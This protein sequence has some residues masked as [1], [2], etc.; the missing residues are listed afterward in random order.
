M[1]RKAQLPGHAGGSL[2]PHSSEDRARGFPRGGRRRWGN[3]DLAF[4]VSRPY[5]AGHTVLTQ[6][7]EGTRQRCFLPT[8]GFPRGHKD[9]LCIPRSHH[10]GCRVLCIRVSV[11]GNPWRPVQQA[12]FCFQL[13]GASPSG[14]LEVR[15]D[16]G[17]PWGIRF[18]SR[19]RIPAPQE[20]HLG[21]PPDLKGRLGCGR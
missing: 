17:W 15:G 12:G 2:D 1:P 19:N 9:L 16:A 13:P 11:F 8:R 14:N 3:W 6:E 21:K 7:G 20:K 5:R 4:S 18:M 10:V